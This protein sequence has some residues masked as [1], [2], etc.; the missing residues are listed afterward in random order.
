MSLRFL[1]IMALHSSLVKLST[2]FLKYVAIFSSGIFNSA[3]SA[4]MLSVISSFAGGVVPNLIAL[5]VGW[6][7]SASRSSPVEILYALSN[8]YLSA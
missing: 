2:D 7:A 4:L 5:G 1:S 6:L 3:S 8:A